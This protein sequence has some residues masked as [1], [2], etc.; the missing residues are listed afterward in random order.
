MY[1]TTCGHQENF[2]NYSKVSSFL[3]RFSATLLVTAEVN[4][5]TVKRHSDYKSTQIAESHVEELLSSKMPI[6]KKV[7][8]VIDPSSPSKTFLIW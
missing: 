3:R 5:T 2:G 6:A 4:T 1:H 7:D 8:T